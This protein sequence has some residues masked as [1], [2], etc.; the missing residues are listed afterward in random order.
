MNNKFLYKIYEIDRKYLLVFDKRFLVVKMR[1]VG[2][3][4]KKIYAVLSCMLMVTCVNASMDKTSQLADAQITET[5]TSLDQTAENSYAANV[6]KVSEVV[7]DSVS[8][9]ILTPADKDDSATA[10][11]LKPNDDNEATES[12]QDEAENLGDATGD[13]PALISCKTLNEQLKDLDET[14]RTNA[15]RDL[16]AIL[17][18]NG[19]SLTFDPNTKTISITNDYSNRTEVMQVNT[20]YKI[21]STENV[22]QELY[23]KFLLTKFSDSRQAYQSF[24]IEI[25]NDD[26]NVY[27]NIENNDE[28]IHQRLY[29]VAISYREKGILYAIDYNVSDKMQLSDFIKKLNDRINKNKSSNL[30]RIKLNDKKTLIF[31]ALNSKNTP[32]MACLNE[33]KIFNTMPSLAGSVNVFFKSV[34]TDSACVMIIEKD[35]NDKY[36]IGTVNGNFDEAD[37]IIIHYRTGLNRYNAF[38]RKFLKLNSK[39]NDNNTNQTDIKVF[40]SIK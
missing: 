5:V 12:N 16:L 14:I 11:D 31:A 15:E 25:V 27:Y 36:E 2:M 20:E 33:E 38:D 3:D 4:V 1:I 32:V 24:N 26:G 30:H 37:K 23:S 34:N 6:Q 39:Q 9:G 21:E 29:S 40:L 17:N 13:I 7:M 28:Y 18:Y 35:E 22:A 8:N 10:S 19:I